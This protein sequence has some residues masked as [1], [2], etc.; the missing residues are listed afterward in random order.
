VVVRGNIGIL[1]IVFFV[2]VRISSF[3]TTGSCQNLQVV[4]GNKGVVYNLLQLFTS[5]YKFGYVD[6]L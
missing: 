1:F 3:S 6:K 5:C 2:K 4:T